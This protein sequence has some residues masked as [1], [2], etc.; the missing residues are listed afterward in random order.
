MLGDIFAEQ[1][2]LRPKLYR[3]PLPPELYRYDTDN[4]LAVYEEISRKVL[5]RRS[6]QDGEELRKLIS[7][8]YLD[9]Q[10][11]VAISHDKVV[12]IGQKPK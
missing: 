3:F 9:S 2:L 8:A 6:K 7:V 4:V 12:V 11:G 1:G 5:D 10:Q